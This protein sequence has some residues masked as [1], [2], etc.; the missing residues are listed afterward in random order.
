MKLDG[1]DGTFGISTSHA[2]GA[3]TLTLVDY[4]TGLHLDEP[5]KSSAFDAYS[6]DAHTGGAT[7][8]PHDGSVVFVS[9]PVVL[10]DAQPLPV[11]M[12]IADGHY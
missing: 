5:V 7:I 9:D 3:V 1:V 10:H 8:A 2:R 4:S 11:L 12:V 6:A